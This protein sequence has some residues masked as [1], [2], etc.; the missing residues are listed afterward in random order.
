[1]LSRDC[2]TSA[3]RVLGTLPAA[4]TLA[5]A[6]LV[7]LPFARA[8]RSLQRARTRVCDSA[9]N[10]G[11]SSGPAG[12]HVRQR[13]RVLL[14]RRCRRREGTRRAARER[15][16][17]RCDLWR[18]LASPPWGPSGHGPTHLVIKP[19]R[20]PRGP[21]LTGAPRHKNGDSGRVPRRPTRQRFPLASRIE[22]G[23][24][25]EIP[26]DAG[27]CDTA[28]ALAAVDAAPIRWSGG[29]ARRVA[30]TDRPSRSC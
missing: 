9:T 30:A 26:S 24:S 7:G 25:A 28:V 8:C 29:W 12:P 2:L 6:T 4:G 1:M 22:T 17:R 23:C 14:R 11:C 5:L 15:A 27:S 18:R 10:E 13:E 20:P 3:S 21:R 19:H 16:E